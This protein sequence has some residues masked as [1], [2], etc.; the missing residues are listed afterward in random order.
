MDKGHWGSYWH[1]KRLKGIKVEEEVNF[2]YREQ[3]SYV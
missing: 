1:R 2:P 3:T